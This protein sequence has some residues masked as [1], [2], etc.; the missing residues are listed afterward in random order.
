M[1][2]ISSSILLK[3]DHGGALPLDSHWSAE[4]ISLFTPQL[5]K[6][7]QFSPAPSL[8]LGNTLVRGYSQEAP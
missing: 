6:I 2:E 5:Y 7:T 8:D 3:E 1:R 4:F